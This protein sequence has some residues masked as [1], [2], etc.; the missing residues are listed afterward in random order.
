MPNARSIVPSFASVSAHSDSGSEAATMPA[1]AKSLIVLSRT[2]PH[3]IATAHSPLPSE[4]HQPTAPL[5]TP[6]SNGSRSPI[7]DRDSAVG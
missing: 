7:S 4:S 3:R 1:P 5:K 6:R 2:V